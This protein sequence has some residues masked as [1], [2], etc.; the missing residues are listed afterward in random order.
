M[1]AAGKFRVREDVGDAADTVAH[2]EECY[3]GN[4]VL[5]VIVVAEDGAR[6]T[7]LHA[8]VTT[9]GQFAWIEE[10]LAEVRQ[11]LS[12]MRIGMPMG[13]A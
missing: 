3:P 6:R 9:A 7:W 11:D 4:R 13:R 10:R 8:D 12:A 5:A 2:F 1:A